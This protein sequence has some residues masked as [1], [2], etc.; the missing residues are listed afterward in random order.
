[1]KRLFVALLFSLVAT[2]GLCQSTD[3]PCWKAAMAQ[4]EMNRCADLDARAADADLNEVYQ[5]LLSKL[6]SDDNASK[7]LRDAQRAWVVFR[8][9]H[10]QELFPAKDKQREYG[11]MYP[12]CYAQAATAMTKERTIQLRRMLEDKAPCDVLGN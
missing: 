7:K 8:D 11:S 4:N 2:S 5:K 12:M 6:K 1:M 9:A 10:L 3:S